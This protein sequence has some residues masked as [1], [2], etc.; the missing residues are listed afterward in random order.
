MV[1]RPLEVIWHTS[2]KTKWDVD[3][4]KKSLEKCKS[5]LEHEESHPNKNPQKIK[6]YQAQIIHYMSRLNYLDQE[7][8]EGR[9]H[10]YMSKNKMRLYKETW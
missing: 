4:L 6:S 3:F 1:D 2:S 5:H 7:R 9:I 8:R 10:R